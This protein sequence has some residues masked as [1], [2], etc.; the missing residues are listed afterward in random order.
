MR[1]V[2]CVLLTMLL[3]S[4]S[5]AAPRT[6]TRA[7]AQAAVGGGDAQAAAAL[8]MTTDQ[9]TCLNEC[10]KRGH[11]TEQCANACRPGLCHPDAEQPYCIAK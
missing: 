7:E 1:L 3:T 8:T 10:T 5:F 2:L 4:S 9:R 11:N 6:L